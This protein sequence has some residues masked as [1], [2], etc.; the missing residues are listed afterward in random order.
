[1]TKEEIKETIFKTYLT[2]GTYSVT[3]KSMYEAFSFQG[4]ADLDEYIEHCTLFSEVYEEGI[5]H[6]GD[7]EILFA[8]TSYKML[9]LGR[10][11]ENMDDDDWVDFA[12]NAREACHGNEDVYVEMTEW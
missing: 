4:P 6:L 8:A 3:D 1:M 11:A 12:Y 2:F 5:E 9:F 7:E 10:F